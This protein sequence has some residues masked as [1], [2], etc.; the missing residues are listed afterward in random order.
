MKTIARSVPSR[1]P[2]RTLRPLVVVVVA[3]AVAAIG[4]G[5]L[6][7]VPASAQVLA[8]P[9]AKAQPGAPLAVT[10]PPLEL[11]ASDGAGL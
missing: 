5:A 9:A 4:A 1:S 3:L 8:P 6:M 7:S 11:T 2:R 10:A